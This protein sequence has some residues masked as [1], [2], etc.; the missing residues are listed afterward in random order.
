[1]EEYDE[2][3]EYEDDVEEVEELEDEADDLDEVEEV[4]DTSEKGRRQL[5]R[6]RLSEFSD[7]LTGGA[8][9]PGEQ[10]VKRSPLVMV[11]GAAIIGLALLGLVFFIM[12]LSEGEARAFKA[13]EDKLKEQAFPEA[14]KR[15]ESFLEAYPDGQFSE[16]ARINLHK[17][18]VQT[19][20]AKEGWSLEDVPA[21]LHELDEFIRV[22]RDMPAFKE[23][24]TDVSRFAE[25]IARVGAIVAEDRRRIEPLEKSQ[26]AVK[27]MEQFAGPDGVKV[28]VADDIRQLQRR[29]EAAI[30]K[31]EV[32]GS[33]MA[34]INGHLEAGDTLSALE[35]R[36][37]LIDSYP[38]LSDD[39]DVGKVLDKILEKEKSLTVQEDIGRDAGTED[40][41]GSTR[42]AASLA[43]RTQKTVDQV[44]QGRLVFAI[45]LDSCYGL[46][47]E[48]GAPVWKRH[49]GSNAP[50][51]PVPVEASQPALLVFHPD[52]NELLLLNQADGA[53]IWRQTVESR[54]SGPPLVFQQQIYL[55][56]ASGE[57]WKISVDTG[58]VISRVVFN[59]PVV[60]PPAVS[61]D[62]R[63]LVL[64]GDQSVIYTLSI[65]PLECVAVSYVEHRLGSVESPILT[66]G[67][68]FLICDND[69]AEKA[70]LRVLDLNEQ[71]G[72]LSVRATET[73][74]G[75]VRD[76]CLIRGRELYVP[77]TPQRVTAFRVNDEPDA[78][79]L[80][81][82]GSNQLENA[83]TSPVF[84]LAGPGG[85]LWMASQALRKF[86][87]R[88]NTLEL[89]SASVAQ[90]LH[91]QPIQLA[92]QNVF[93]T[94]NE[95]Y[96]SS[97]FFTKVEPQ[98]MADLW[99][100]VV[101]TNVV[102]ASSNASGDSLLAVGDFGKVFRVPTQVI[103]SGEFVIDS[104][105]DYRIP[106]KLREPVGGLALKDGRVAAY[107]GGEEP[108][109][110]TM[111]RTGLL[112]QKWTLSGPPQVSPVSL[113]AGVVF[114]VPG[115]L[116]M[117]GVNGQRIEDYSAAQ[118]S[119]Q[120]AAWKCL[121]A[122]NDTQVMAV[123][124]RNQAVRVEYRTSPSPHLYEVSVT[125]L[126]HSVEI[127][128]ANAGEFLAV[129]TADGKLVMMST[130]TFE[131]LSETEL[132]G[133]STQSP[134][135][136]GD[137]I[138]VEVGRQQIKVF[139]RSGTPGQTGTFPLDGAV[140]TG[141]PVQARDGRFV[142][143]RSDGVVL[144]LDSDGNVAGEPLNLGQGVR[145]GPVVVGDTLVAIG[146]DGSLYSIEDVLN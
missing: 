95:P 121:T 72:K 108:S 32:L 37:A 64:S 129:V 56:M 46:D 53:L 117:A 94:T 116:H 63:F 126:Q 12:I 135:V 110:W 80:A 114:G 23:E 145:I 102:A 43:L 42:P 125:Q 41:P 86:Q 25:R 75:Q 97:I 96:S 52:A 40:L 130:A 49:V 20:T 65:S 120:Q 84:L 9:R 44:S 87:V 29:A 131:V 91:L 7:K 128:P 89:D 27:L 144:I 103:H 122:L 47:S 16:Q 134:F 139:E 59:Q 69:S 26:A 48:T 21:A 92:D 111:T 5:R 51:P 146:V 83:A 24:R 67:R 85:Q 106:D 104:V 33:A 28:S 30:R 57:L 11:L 4:E 123:D 55:T 61:R 36:Q 66:M 54:P 79:P 58:R 99:R 35:S 19:Y 100:T 50:F 74:D 39:S 76:E 8:A 68:V 81:R 113:A 3:D 31:A 140:L 124:G 93:L 77:S 60:G 62:S 15:F 14:E 109:M 1:M 6:G 90:G 34:E 98:K 17:A 70:R 142:A 22:C 45:G 88:T 137:R 141:I 132:N 78:E 133:I 13:A 2:V 127:S 71:S 105:S 119:G 138:F 82:V 136:S 143:V 112:E 118:G 73:V 10:D 101:G 18:R 38:V 115:R 107:C